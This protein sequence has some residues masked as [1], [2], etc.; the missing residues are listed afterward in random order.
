[1]EHRRER[2]AARHTLLG[3]DPDEVLTPGPVHVVVRDDSDRVVATVPATE[4]ARAPQGCGIGKRGS[5]R[6]GPPCAG[7]RPGRKDGC[8][9]L[10]NVLGAAFDVRRRTLAP[11]TVSSQPPPPCRA[12]E[13]AAWAAARTS[14]SMAWAR[15]LQHHRCRPAAAACSTS[16]VMCWSFS[17][18]TS[19]AATGSN[20]WAATSSTNRCAMRCGVALHPFGLVEHRLDG[21]A[22]RTSAAPAASTRMLGTTKPSPSS[23]RCRAGRPAEGLGVWREQLGQLLERQPHRLLVRSTAWPAPARARAPR[24]RRRPRAHTASRSAMAASE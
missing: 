16:S 22:G 4:P 6:G 18:E 21:H 1:M 13:S 7:K 17:G 15:M 20:T 24:R 12:V 23:S 2:H 11:R 8:G 19:P 5:G 3:A 10:T 9:H 14:R